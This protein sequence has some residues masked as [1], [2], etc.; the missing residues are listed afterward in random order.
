MNELLDSVL[1]F[2]FFS[3]E[4]AVLVVDTFL[5]NLVHNFNPT[6]SSKY[7]LYAASLIALVFGRTFV[8]SFKKAV[9]SLEERYTGL[10]RRGFEELR[11]EELLTELYI[12]DDR[13]IF[14]LAQALY[15]ENEIN[16]L[17]AITK[18]DKWFIMK[19]K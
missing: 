8:S 10:L 2:G 6:N 12:Q 19:I 9:T 15:N 1:V 11:N 4:V 3:N 7:S 17:C 5:I 16:K 18:I 14:R 13:R